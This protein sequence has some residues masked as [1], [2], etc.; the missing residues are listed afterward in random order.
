VALFDGND[1]ISNDVE[2]V[3]ENLR[4]GYKGQGDVVYIKP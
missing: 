1:N 4:L 3:A 2:A